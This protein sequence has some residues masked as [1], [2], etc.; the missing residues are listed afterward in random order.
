[1]NKIII[2]ILIFLTFSCDDSKKKNESEE[3]KSEQKEIV[4]SEPEGKHES[5]FEIVFRKIEDVE[6]FKDFVM[7]SAT[8]INYEDSKW[9]YAFIEVQNQN[10]RIII[11]ERIIETGKPEKNHQILDTI[12][13]NDISKNEFISIG[14]CQNNEKEDSR[15]F[16]IIERTEDDFDLEYYSKIKSA[17]RV[18]LETKKIEKMAEISEITCMNEGYGV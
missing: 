4:I 8:V 14:L 11:F 2:Y 6:Y 17:W 9:E 16:S 3:L 10:K 7:N 5:I 15:I 1:M 18:N 12:H 13:I